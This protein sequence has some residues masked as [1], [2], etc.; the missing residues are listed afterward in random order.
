MTTDAQIARVEQTLKH[1]AR[2]TLEVD[3]LTLAALVRDA[4]KLRQ[5]EQ[6]LARAILLRQSH[7]RNEKNTWLN[8]DDLLVAVRAHDAPTE[9]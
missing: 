9:G 6:A 1:D 7:C 5:I 2:S 8:A 4:K 3:R